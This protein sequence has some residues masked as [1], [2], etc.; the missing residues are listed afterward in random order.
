MILNKRCFAGDENDNPE[1][2][3]NLAEDFQLP[4]LGMDEG[5]FGTVDNG[6][7]CFCCGQQASCFVRLHNILLLACKHCF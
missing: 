3:Y 1:D 2:D 7:L 4:P 5:D 6:M